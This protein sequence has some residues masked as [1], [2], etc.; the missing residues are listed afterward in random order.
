[1]TVTPLFEA[2]ASFEDLL[3]ELPPLPE[4]SGVS[5]SAELVG[6]LSFVLSFLRRL[7][8]CLSRSKNHTKKS[9]CS[10][11]SYP[12]PFFHPRGAK[13]EPFFAKYGHV[14]D[15]LTH[16]AC[17]ENA[18][19]RGCVLERPLLFLSA[20]TSGF[21]RGRTGERR[22]NWTR[23]RVRPCV[24]SDRSAALKGGVCIEPW[25][26]GIN[27]ASPFSVREGGRRAALTAASWRS[28]SSTARF[29]STAIVC[30][31]CSRCVVAEACALRHVLR[32]WGRFVLGDSC[33]CVS[34]LCACGARL[35]RSEPSLRLR[36]TAPFVL[37]V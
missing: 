20:R 28:R 10:R 12:V 30:S 5:C 13:L 22:S 11:G 36:T 15:V 9:Q 7:I 34:C 24:A 16:G 29:S 18:Y 17:F 23:A 35:W 25:L 33:G 8:L 1:M 19:F 37:R 31:L 21:A 3:P 6:T 26:R 14:W 2:S 32:F 27:E 4:E